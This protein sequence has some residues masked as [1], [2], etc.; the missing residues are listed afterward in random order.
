MTDFT[1]R[2]FQFFG[3]PYRF[4]NI[5]SD[6]VHQVLHPLQLDLGYREYANYSATKVIAIDVLIVLLSQAT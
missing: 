5:Y 6:Q 1:G 2:V 4:Y 3:E